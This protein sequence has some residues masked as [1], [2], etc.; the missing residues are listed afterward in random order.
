MFDESRIKI[1]AE[2][3]QALEGRTFSVSPARDAEYLAAVERGDMETA[4]RMVDEAAKKAGYDVGPVFHASKEDFNSFDITRAK[5]KYPEF[6]FTGNKGYASNHGANVRPF[7]LKRPIFNGEPDVWTTDQ[8]TDI[9]SADPVTR[10][11]SGNVIP[12][13]QRFNAASNDIR[14]SVSPT[15]HVELL[16]RQVDAQLKRDPERRRKLAKAAGDKLQ[17]LQFAWETDRVNERGVKT[18]AIVEQRSERSLNKEQAFRE[19]ARREEL[20]AEVY[21]VYGDVLENES[22]GQL[23]GAGPVMEYLSKPDDKLH[24]RLMSKS[25][26]LKSGKFS[27]SNGDYDGIDGVP[28]VVFGGSL[29]PDQVAQ[30]LFESGILKDASVDVLWDTIRDELKSAARWKGFIKTAKEGLKKAK[31]QAHEEAAEWRREQDEL[32]REDWNPKARLLRDMRALD[33]VISVLPV[34]LRSKVGGFIKLAELTTDKARIKEIERRMKKLGGLVEDHLKKESVEEIERLIEKAEPSTGPGEKPK[35]KITVEGHRVFAAVD[36]VRG[37]TTEQV[38]AERSRLATAIEDKITK[39]EDVID[40]LEQEQILEMFGAIGEKTAAEA[41]AAASWLDKVYRTGRNAWRMMEEARLAEVADLKE[42]TVKAIG[43]ASKSGT[44]EQKKNAAKLRAFAESA[45][46]QL[47]SFTQVLESVVGA[48]HPLVARWSRAAREATNQ[49]TDAILAANAR[50]EKAARDAFGGV[51]KLEMSRRLWGM[52][53]DQRISLPVVEG[54][55]SET[56]TVPIE[57]IRQFEDGSVNPADLGYSPE[58]AA[59]L[60]DQLNALPEKSRKKNLS[61]ERILPGETKPAKYTEAEVLALTMLAKQEQYLPN[62]EKHGYTA[63]V[64]EAA[65]SSLSDA[66]KAI[67]SHL[68]KEYADGY[69]PLSKVFR[70]MFGIDLPS[71]ANYS[72]AAFLHAGETRDVDPFGG[73]VSEG[74]FRAGFLKSRKEHLAAPRIENAL[75]TWQ[76]HVAQT[77][78]W[79]A[80][81]P[82]V[83]ELRAVFGSVDVKDSILSNRGA[84]LANA[85][86]A[87]VSAL[88]QN[89]LQQRAFLSALN[90]VFRYLTGK[91]ATLTL[92][93]KA[94]TLIKQSLAAISSAARLPAG[95]WLRGL[96]RVMS[97]KIDVSAIRNSQMIQRR[98][99][100]G[101]SPEVRAAMVSL[102]KGKP[103][104]WSQFVEAGMQKIG[105]VDAFFT[106]IGTA[107]VYDYHYNEGLKNDMSE[108]AAREMALVEAEDNLGRTAQPVELMDRSLYELGMS[109]AERVGFM[110]ASNQRK[111]SALILSA[112]AQYKRGNITGAQFGQ[113]L[114]VA[115]LAV[116]FGSALLGAAWR[117]ANDDDDDA[118]LDWDNWNPVDI[119]RQALLGPLGGIP[120][121]NMAYNSLLGYGPNDPFKPVKQM[122]SAVAKIDEGDKV[123]PVEKTVRRAVDIANG[124]AI[125][126]PKMEGIAIGANILEQAFNLADNFVSDTEDEA[127]KKE[128]AALAKERKAAKGE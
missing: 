122:K 92:A 38:D 118:W 52:S 56:L 24:G 13:S 7:Y 107:I 34:D 28:R 71:V 126:V 95:V 99:E 97:G 127:T 36:A 57:K 128:K 87:W 72:P 88:E 125:F 84:G 82:L 117:D 31:R 104:V 105:E 96:S 83:R 70:D 51:S 19:A 60:I 119:S 124:A 106:S 22:L 98:I 101:F 18:R 3:D 49:R 79:R 90:P 91:Q 45:S 29:M 114:A 77:E 5:G 66:A 35:G 48:G 80:F 39:G 89:G 42:Q 68:L 74:G 108:D 59:D 53:N 27:E 40:L 30:E 47:L 100:S 112:W 50:F 46:F 12:L 15:A 23:W 37:L 8:N 75:Q 121:L 1:T 110:F 93:W 94:G 120:L 103:S 54:G 61:V 55:R 73:M 10:D 2:N 4:Q 16:Q 20:E 109:P 26:A 102:F 69:A 21:G 43:A 32:Q 17:A 62:L 58:E 11:E 111:D 9:K 113:T 76:G 14:F 63:E 67:R 64:I 78:H 85:A 81:A 65:E 116:G 6:W 33:A 115:W 123:E 44:Q 86:Q 41:D 25:Q